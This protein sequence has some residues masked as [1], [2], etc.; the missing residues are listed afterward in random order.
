[1]HRPEFMRGQSTIA[2]TV[3]SWTLG[4]VYGNFSLLILVIVKRLPYT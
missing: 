3:F 4:F 1:L 2:L